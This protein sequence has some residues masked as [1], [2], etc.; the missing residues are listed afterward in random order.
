MKRAMFFL[1]ALL[2]SAAAF[3]PHYL[4][5]KEDK[6]K[7]NPHANSNRYHLFQFDRYPGFYS[8]PTVFSMLPG[9]VLP[10]LRL[11]MMLLARASHLQPPRLHIPGKRWGRTVMEG[12][13]HI[14]YA[15][16][17]YWIRQEVNKED[18]EYHWTWE[19]QKRRFLFLDG[20]RFDS[21]S[22][23]FNWTH[24]MAGAMYYNYARANRLN[25]LESFLFTFGSSYLWEFAVE[26][27]EV[28]SINDMICTPMGGVS[29]GEALFQLG[30]LFRSKRPTFLNKIARLLSNPILSLNEWLDR[31]KY[32]DQ[33]SFGSMDYWNQS[34]LFIGPRFDTFSGSD[35]N[36]FLRAGLESQINFVPEYGKP[37]VS[38][39]SLPIP[40]FTQFDI[41]G[42]F[43]QKG[44]FEYNIFAKA[45]LFGHFWQDIRVAGSSS[46]GTLNAA[47]PEDAINITD[48]DTLAR[49][50]VGY[51]LMLGMAS[52][53]DFIEIN[54]AIVAEMTGPGDS[55]S[56][57]RVDKFTVINLLGPTVDFSLFHRDLAVR[58][59]A[60]AY[61]DFS[62]IYSHAFQKYSQFYDFGQTKSTLENHGYYYALGITLSSLLQVN[63]ANLELRGRFKYHYFDSVEGMDRFQKEI[64]KAD[65]FDLKDQRWFYHISLGYTIP[66]TPVQLA[67]GLE[68]WDRKGMIKD[69]VQQSSERRSYFQIRYLF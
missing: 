45:V 1:I 3:S 58:L 32:R 44:L 38:N 22:Y 14:L 61:G 21:N 56:G 27:K 17:S 12:L 55:S 40:A 51:S 19:D 52:C 41:G 7:N 15:T 6:T 69:F 8:I 63:L 36:A 47:H 68:Q 11:N 35:T 13:G 9:L 24:S 66:H 30:R 65:D 10:D 33:Y 53:F 42:A 46:P 57:D 48:S 28:I 43:N 2:F 29:I 18:W 59:V 34:R 16:S 5:A 39:R 60:D 4:S 64:A 37:D 62:M 54:S 20:V 31:K 50:R 67:L 49:R 25:S 26:F 23:Q